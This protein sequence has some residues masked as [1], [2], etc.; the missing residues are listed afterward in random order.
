ML[1]DTEVATAAGQALDKTAVNPFAGLVATNGQVD[2]PYAAGANVSTE[3]FQATG[4]VGYTIGWPISDQ[5]Y[6]A[7][8]IAGRAA[9]E[10]AGDLLPLPATGNVTAGTYW[11]Y[12]DE[13]VYVIQTH[14]RSTFGG[15][16]FQ[17]ASLNRLYRNP[18]RR[19]AWHQPI[20]QYDSFLLVNAI[21][22]LPDET[23]HAGQSWRTRRNNNVWTPG[24]SDSGWM[25]VSNLP[26]PWVH[27]GNEGYPLG[28]QVTHNGHL[29]Q[30]SANNVFWEPGVALWSDLGVYGA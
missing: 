11:Y 27:V 24:T 30:A 19:Y 6:T 2:V 29:W 22:G 13:I 7:A 1:V 21:T 16:P 25:R 17:Y 3:F 10:W 12:G 9:L 5:G 23:D 26:A 8:N 15:D 18:W 4:E 14:N 28:W 20:D